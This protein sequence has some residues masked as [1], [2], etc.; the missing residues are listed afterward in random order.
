[1]EALLK[2]IVG[3]DGVTAETIVK[4]GWI[5]FALKVAQFGSVL[6]GVGI[7]GQMML[8]GQKR[9]FEHDRR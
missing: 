5:F 8:L 3:I 4:I 9:W 6:V 7:V 1:M 2:L